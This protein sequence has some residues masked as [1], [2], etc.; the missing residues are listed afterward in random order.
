MKYLGSISD[1]KS[2]V[3]KEYV[4]GNILVLQTEKQDKEEG[5][6]LSSN[7][8]SDSDKSKVDSL[9]N[10]VQ[11]V[12]TEDVLDDVEV[13]YATKQYVD[14]EFATK[15][16]HNSLNERVTALEEEGGSSVT[17]DTELSE[18]SENA[19]SNS[20]VTRA[21]VEN[22]EVTAAAL[23]E[24]NE[25][26]NEISENVS[27][28]TVTKEE[29]EEAIKTLSDA[30]VAINEAISE[31]DEKVSSLETTVADTYA[32]KA[33]LEENVDT[34]NGAIDT[35]QKEVIDNEEVVAAALNDLDVRVKEVSANV[36][37]ETA[38]KVELQDAVTS[39]TNTILENEEVHAAALNDL[40]TRLN[41]ILTRLNTVGI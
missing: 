7:D 8:Y 13:N 18:T 12:A 28:S 33:E 41:E 3:T 36:S 25:R 26:V 15:T 11:A 2:H 5:K 39:L 19:I 1:S 23:N 31:V 6:G 30:D 38:T 10:V 32:T 16:E 20:A 9:V 34:I 4:D 22:E 35:L 17:V 27:G 29:F 37:G 24:L 14:S 21:M 40:N